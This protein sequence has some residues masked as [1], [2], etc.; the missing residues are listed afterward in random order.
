MNDT[1]SIVEMVSILF[2]RAHPRNTELPKP[3]GQRYTAKIPD[4]MREAAACVPRAPSPV[5]S[6]QSALSSLRKA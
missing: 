3:S 1:L 5:L 4:P 6:L 2:A